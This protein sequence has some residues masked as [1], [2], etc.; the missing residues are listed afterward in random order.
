[1]KNTVIMFIHGFIGHVNEYKFIDKFFKDNGYDTH[2]FS[3]SGHKGREIENVKS[4]WIDDC[5]KNIDY[6]IDKDIKG[7]SCWS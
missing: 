3:L 7:Y 5:N 2:I 4:D 6:L 1:M